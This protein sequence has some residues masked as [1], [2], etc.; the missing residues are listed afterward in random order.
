MSQDVLAEIQNHL[1]DYVVGIVVPMD[2][3]GSRVLGSGVLVSIEGRRGL[4][5]CGHVADKYGDLTDIGLAQFIAG[6]TQ[7]R[8]VP[9]SDAQKL[10]LGTN[11]KKIWTDTDFDLAFTYFWPEVAGSVGAKSSF[12]NIERNR[13]RIEGGQSTEDKVVDIMFGLVEEYSETPVK[14]DGQIISP[15]RAVIYRGSMESEE[16]GL[17]RFQTADDNPEVLPKSFGGLSGSGLW[18]VHLAEQDGKVSISEVR[19]WGIASY[20]VD[21]ENNS[22]Q[23][24]GQGWDRI[25]QGLVVTVR[26]KLPIWG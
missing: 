17:I 7:R 5:T 21:K 18:R 9:I 26:E 22:G 23:V 8:T 14:Q 19:L 12:L 11:E 16:G 13:E 24:R 3:G 10:I 15:M 2:G 6:T 1:A 4:L 20:Q 25:D